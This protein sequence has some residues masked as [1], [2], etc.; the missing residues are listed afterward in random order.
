MATVTRKTTA[1]AKTTAKTT[2]TNK[3]V[4]TMSNKSESTTRNV[5]LKDV[6][7]YWVKCDPKNPVD[8]PFGETQ[9]EVQ[10]RVPLKRKGELEEYSNRVQVCADDKKMVQCNFRKKAFKKDGDPAQPVAIVGTLKGQTYESRIVGNGSKGNVMLMLRDYELKGPKG[11]VTK[12]G[13]TVSLAKIQVTE[14]LKYEPKGSDFDYDG[15]AETDSGSPNGDKDFDMEDDI[16][17]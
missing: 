13:T 7:L 17:F 6:V 10:V 9:W 12:S 8:T 15:E 4:K 1:T 3:E 11:N 2:V 5:I 14:L 16:P